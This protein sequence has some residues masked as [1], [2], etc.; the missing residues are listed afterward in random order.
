[1]NLPVQPFLLFSHSTLQDNLESS[2]YEVFEK[3][4]TK[5]SQYEEAVYRALID[6]VPEDKKEQVVTTVR[7]EGGR[8]WVGLVHGS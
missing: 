6:R 7:S 1:M 4:V 5:Y 8:Y 2:T 3:D